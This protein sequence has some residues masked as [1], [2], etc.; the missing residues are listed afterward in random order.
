MSPRQGDV[1]QKCRHLAVGAPCCRHVADIPSQD[2]HRS[3]STKNTSSWQQ[4]GSWTKSGNQKELQ[5]S[6]GTPHNHRWNL[7]E[8]AIQTF[9]NHFKAILAG[10]DDNL[11]MRLWDKLLPQTVLTLNLLRQSN[12]APT[13]LAYQYIHGNF[14]YNKMPLAPL[15]CTVQL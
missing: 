11:P 15:G 10:V 9:K 13:V 3:N 7:A 8:R 14:N 12:V 6:I 2:N 5:D 1:G 4:S